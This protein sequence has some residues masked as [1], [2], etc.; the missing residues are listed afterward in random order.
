MQVDS[1]SLPTTHRG[2]EAQRNIWIDLCASVPL[3]V[4]GR[5]SVSL[6]DC[7]CC[8]RYSGSNCRPTK[9]DKPIRL[10]YLFSDGNLPGTLKAFKALLQERPDLRGK[11]QL[12]FVTESVLT[13]VNADELKTTDVLLLDTMNQ[14]LLERVNADRKL[15]LIATVRDRRGKVFAIGEGLLPKETYIKQGALW[16]DRARAYWAHMGFSN[17]V[18]LMKYALTQAG[19]RGLALPAPQPKSGFRL[20]L[21]GRWPVRK[22]R[23][24]NVIRGGACSA[25]RRAGP[26]D[27]HPGRSSRRGT[28]S[29]RGGRRTARSVPARRASP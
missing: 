1:P 13:D 5:V 19:I 25:D 9:P 4:R 22:E 10:T 16:D 14:Q 2:T 12:T 27:R 21:P 17:Q 24:Y 28:N 11:V 8:C 20:L 15:D 23:P 6:W 7:C 26:S 29:T 18:G 3:C